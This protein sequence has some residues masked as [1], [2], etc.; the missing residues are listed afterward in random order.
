MVEQPK[1]AGPRQLWA[2]RPRVL[3]AARPAAILP[4]V[5]PVLKLLPEVRRRQ[6]PELAPVTLAGG[7]R[8]ARSML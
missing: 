8:A 1:R 4:F 5:R 2:R 3:K 7:F 6:H